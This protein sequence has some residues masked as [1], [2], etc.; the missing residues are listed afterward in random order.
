MADRTSARIF[1]MVF[2]HL[3]EEASDRDKAM[4]KR[5]WALTGEFDFSPYQMYCDE[6]LEKLGLAERGGDGDW[7][8][9]S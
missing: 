3:A 1:A 8:Y 7:E 6:A 2:E 4:A 9:G 5:L